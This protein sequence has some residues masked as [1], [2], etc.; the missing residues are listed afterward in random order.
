[1]IQHTKGHIFP[2]VAPGIS[3]SARLMKTAALKPCVPRPSSMACEG[4]QVR[5]LLLIATTMVGMPRM[6]LR[7]GSAYD[8]DNS[9][10]G[11]AMHA[12][13][14]CPS[15]AASMELDDFMDTDQT[16]GYMEGLHGHADDSASSNVGNSSW[17]SS[18]EKSCHSGGEK[19]GRTYS[20]GKRRCQVQDCQKL[21]FYGSSIGEPRCGKASE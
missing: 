8:E 4:T 2:A 1:M 17:T 16:D 5:I 21:P 11:S 18:A 20:K 9:F 12:P 6:K 10:S 19:H 7:G 3:F 14:S 15:A 13:A